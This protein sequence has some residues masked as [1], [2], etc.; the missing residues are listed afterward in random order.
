MRYALATLIG[1]LTCSTC[2]GAETEIDM[3]LGCKSNPQLVGVCF[4]VHGRLSAY[5]GTPS[6]RIWP[7][8]THQLLGILKDEDPLAIPES[9]RNSIGFDKDVYGDFLVCPFSQSKPGHM[10]FVCVG[11]VSNV[12]VQKRP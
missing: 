2:F 6:L 12:R 3:K 5:N 10:Q 1:L 8:G 9:I 11:A 7:V 4:S